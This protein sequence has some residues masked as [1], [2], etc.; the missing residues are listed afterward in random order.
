MFSSGLCMWLQLAWLG[1]LRV[2][3][4]DS[5]QQER[6]IGPNNGGRRGKDDTHISITRWV[7]GHGALRVPG[8]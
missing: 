6:Y 7:I 5:R 2:P 8:R 4:G 1:M 3:E